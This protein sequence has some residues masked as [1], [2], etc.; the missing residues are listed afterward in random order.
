MPFALASAIRNSNLRTF[1][2]IATPFQGLPINFEEKC[3]NRKWV[4]PAT[5][6]ICINLSRKWD[7]LWMYLIFNVKE[8]R[9]CEV[10]F[11][12]W[13]WRFQKQ[14]VPSMFLDPNLTG[15]VWICKE[16][17]PAGNGTFQNKSSIC[18]YQSSCKYCSTTKVLNTTSQDFGVNRSIK[19]AL[20]H[21]NT[22]SSAWLFRRAR[23]SFS[24]AHLVA[25]EL[26]ARHCAAVYTP[27][28][29]RCGRHGKSNFFCWK[30]Y[31]KVFQLCERDFQ[32]WHLSWKARLARQI[33][34]DPT[35]QGLRRGLT[36][37]TQNMWETQNTE[38][39][40]PLW[41]VKRSIENQM[42]RFWLKKMNPPVPASLVWHQLSHV[43]CGV[44]R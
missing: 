10:W 26:H 14:T 35:Y 27:S 30:L 21:P 39:W 6:T 20:V 16:I 13:Y 25:A 40:G 12:A 17:C 1:N 42:L 43:Q 8:V 5:G 29:K 24:A 15:A 23:L 44:I 28:V 3:S 36:K 38:R 31:N 22:W 32:R 11:W 18:M 2:R 7:L 33:L 37:N 41:L 9:W 4:S 19:H 34:W